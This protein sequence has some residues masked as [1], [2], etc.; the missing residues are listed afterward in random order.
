VIWLGDKRGNLSDWTTQQ[1]VRAT[2]RRV[3]LKEQPWL[4]G[5]TG[6]TQLI[7]KDFFTDYARKNNL[8]LVHSG[9]RGLIE[10]LTLLSGAQA[11]MALVAKPVRDFYE[12]TSEYTLDAWSKWHGLFQPFGRALAVLFSRRL[13]QLN[14]PLSPLDSAKGMNSSVVQLRDPNSG[15][16]IQTAWVRELNATK[17]ILYAGSYSICIVPGH[18][19]P[20]IRVVFPLPNGNAMVIMKPEIHKDGSLS[21]TSAGNAFGDPGFYFVV[22]GEGGAVWARY[23]RSMKETIHVYPAESG[24]VRAD[25]ILWLWGKQFLRLHYRMQPQ[26]TQR[27]E[28]QNS[29][30]LI[31]TG[32]LQ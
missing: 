30:P 8:D 9:V 27:P 20:C 19:S 28:P 11:D 6:S 7:G 21:V 31:H 17:N 23:L 25:H 5:P 1:W 22:H 32:L 10:D 29:T 3:V 18:P 15:R 14:I 16:L 4:D 12:R 2:G 26:P 24:I 13:Q